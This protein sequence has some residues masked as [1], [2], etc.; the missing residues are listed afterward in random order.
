[1]P[2]NNT[3]I[4]GGGIAGLY[5][6]YQLKKRGEP[7]Q[8]VEKSNRSAL[9]GR[10]GSPLFFGVPVPK[11]A[12]IGRKRKDKLLQ[13]LLSDLKVQSHEFRA[14]HQY[15]ETIGSHYC[16]VKTIFLQLKQEFENHPT[17]YEGLT[18]KQFAQSQLGKTEYKQFTTCAGY[19]D[20]ENEDVRSTLYDYGFDD[21]YT[22]FTGISIPWTELL[23][24]LVRTIGE[25]NIHCHS[26]VVRIDQEGG[27]ENLYYTVHTKTA[28]FDAKRVIIA[29]TIHSLR[30]LLP[31]IPEYKLIE[32]QPFLRIYGRFSQSSIPIL[33]ENLKTTTIV[34]GQLHKLIP[35]NPAKGIY[36][37]VYTDNKGARELNEYAKNTAP[38]CHYLQRQI[39]K[40]LLLPRDSLELESIL[41]FYWEEGTHYYKPFPKNTPYKTRRQF[42]K[43]AQHPYPNIYVVG[44]MIS[45]NQGWVEGALE[46]VKRIMSGI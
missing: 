27:N 37:I 46:S 39:E 3:I 12:G 1:M 11:G 23:D 26:E 41:S 10:M 44:E 36:M 30:Q 43:A 4:I 22:N 34:P 7:F 9:G 45:Q 21:N 42:I 35:M 18:F 38:N 31:R 13:Q 29:T 40:V 33:Q 20:Y 2:T 28:S 19:T 16:N 5:V 25:K 6:A 8:L 32:S 15:A 17:K 24:K 14:T